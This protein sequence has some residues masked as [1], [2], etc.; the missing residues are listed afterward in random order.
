[1]AT[2]VI[3]YQIIINHMLFDMPPYTSEL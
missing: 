1:M 2:Y 3:L